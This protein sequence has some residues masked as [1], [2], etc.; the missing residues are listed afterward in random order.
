MAPILKYTAVHRALAQQ[1]NDDIIDVFGKT[2]TLVF[3]AITNPCVNC[4]ADPIGGKSSNHFQHGGPMPFA[5]G[6]SCPYCDGQGM[7]ADVT[8][9]DVKFACVYD[10][11]EYLDPNTRIVIRIPNGV[12]EIRGYLTDLPDVEQCEYILVQSDINSITKRRFKL[13]TEPIDDN[14]IVPGRYF[15]AKLE[16]MG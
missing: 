8:T 13:M 9:R 6:S 2:C 1:G 4:I 3:P 14:N 5:N 12:C 16:R 15:V 7:R 11:K 10:V